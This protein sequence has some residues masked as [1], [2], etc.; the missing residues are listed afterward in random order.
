MRQ[1]FLAQ[2]ATPGGMPP[3]DFARLIQDEVTHWR[4]VASRAGLNP[5]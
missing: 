2:G 5:Q 3:D 1:F 4:V